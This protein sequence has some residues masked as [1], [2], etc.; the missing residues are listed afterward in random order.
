MSKCI[1][2]SK[3][4]TSRFQKKFCS[5]SCSASY[6]N[7]AR[8]EPPNICFN[9]GEKT[10]SKNHKYCN[11]NCYIQHQKNITLQKILKGT[12][13]SYVVKHYLLKTFGHYCNRCKNTYW[14]DQ[15]IP[16]ELEHIDGN[17]KN[18]SLDNV[19]LLCP[20]CHAQ[21]PTYKAKN[22]GNGRYS[23][24]QRYKQGLSY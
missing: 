18:N 23:R 14:N 5:H 13:S 12:A 16:I 21:T 1:Y 11:K 19:E 6:N 3:E 17:S 15:L 10:P 7:K 4:L 8:R 2:C 20:N 22:K 9:C 24:R